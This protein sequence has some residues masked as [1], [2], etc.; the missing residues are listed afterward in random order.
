MSVGET[1]AIMDQYFDALRTRGDF[2]RFFSQ[3]TEFTA[4]GTDQRAHGADAVEQAIRFMHEVAFDARPEVSNIV[5]QERGAAAEIAFV[6]T[7]IGEFAGIAATN[8]AVRVPYCVF[9]D[10]DGPAITALR[11]YMPMERLLE[12]VQRR[13]DTE[14]ASPGT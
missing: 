9:Y 3:D 11:V 10:L 8:N 2:A 1:R 6:G 14:V 5:I 12:Q 7:H 4:V 13:A